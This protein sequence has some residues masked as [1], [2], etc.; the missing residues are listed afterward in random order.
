MC[1]SG[2]ARPGHCSGIKHH[3]LKILK[4]PTNTEIGFPGIFLIDF[5]TTNKKLKIE[6]IMNNLV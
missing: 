3:Q 2:I 4:K 6:V 1:S 5:G